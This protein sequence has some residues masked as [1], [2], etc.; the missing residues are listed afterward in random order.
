LRRSWHWNRTANGQHAA[1]LWLQQQGQQAT[2]DLHPANAEALATI[3]TE[4]GAEVLRGA[5]H[6]PGESGNWQLGDV[7]LDEHLSKYRDR[8]VVVIIAS[9]SKTGKSQVVCG[10]YDFAPDEASECTRCRLMVEEA[11]RDIKAQQEAQDT[12]FREVEEILEKAWRG[13]DQG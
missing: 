5:L 4:T 13:S 8:N 12:L 9:M 11:A 2:T 1:L 7:D 10:I 3:A 6:Y